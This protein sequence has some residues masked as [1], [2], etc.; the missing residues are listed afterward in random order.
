MKSI[1]YVGAGPA[2]VFSVLEL[3]KNKADFEIN[4]FEK[5][6]S[7]YSRTEKEIV[8]GFGGAGAISDNKLS[9][10]TQVGGIIPFLDE[11]E[12]DKYVDKLV[13]FYNEFLDEK[14]RFKLEE[15]ED[16]DVGIFLGWIR[17]RTHHVGTDVGRECFKKIEDFIKSQPNIHIFFETEINE[18]D[19][20]KNGKFRVHTNTGKTYDSDICIVGTGQRGTLPAYIIKKFNLK[21]TARPFQLG[22]RV[23]DERNLMYDKMIKANYDFKVYKKFD[24]GKGKSAR[25]RTFCCNSGVPA[26]T[27]EDNNGMFKSFNGHSY[28]N[29]TPTNKVNY[30]ILCETN[31]LE[32]LNT[33]EEQ[34][35]LCRAINK[36]PGFEEDNKEGRS[37][38][39]DWVKSVRETGEIGNKNIL[40]IYPK[41]VVD[42]IQEFI[43]YF[44]DIC[45]TSKARYFYPE[46]KFDGE[47]VKYSKIFET[48]E[49]GLFVIGDACC[50]RGI[51]KS[52]Y[53][54][55]KAAD[56]IL[57]L[58]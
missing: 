28:K 7:L 5:G 49:K 46:A 13:D 29:G 58:V 20:L 53:T 4:I 57:G 45:D 47:T 33:K 32:V 48:S 9:I 26:I 18:V 56:G 1:T 12:F 34:F 31:G 30:G 35:E 14:S 3:I 54:G 6:K 23:E 51:A 36:E 39:D 38:Y 24:L 19:K 37:L 50:T 17:H 10:S 15:D 25:V 43:L 52:A 11:E 42:C 16:L 41:C 55:M 8:S 27:V 21:T 44:R 2:T 22:I 40:K